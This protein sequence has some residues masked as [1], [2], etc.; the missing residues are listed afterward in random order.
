MASRRR[1]QGSVWTVAAMR[2]LGRTNEGRSAAADDLD[3][4]ACAQAR[5]ESLTRELKLAHS[6]LNEY[7][8]RHGMGFE[9]FQTLFSPA[10]GEQMQYDYISWSYWAERTRHLAQEHV[11]A[12]EVAARLRLRRRLRVETDEELGDRTRS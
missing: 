7:E 10:L 1:G 9:E 8:S 3:P 6:R 2:E 5:L 12:V 11:R 4:L